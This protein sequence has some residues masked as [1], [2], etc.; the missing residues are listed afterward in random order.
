MTKNIMNTLLKDFN[1][2][3]IYDIGFLL[4]YKNFNPKNI[5]NHY[6]FIKDKYKNKIYSKKNFYKI[7]QILITYFIQK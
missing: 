7:I 1:Y 2:Q 6:N 3:E 4:N 5:I